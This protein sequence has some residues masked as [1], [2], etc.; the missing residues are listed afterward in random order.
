MYLVRKD[1]RM[2][3]RVKEVVQETKKLIYVRV[4]GIKGIFFVKR[5]GKGNN[6]IYNRRP[7]TW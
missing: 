2:L 1:Q 4:E 7:S 3:C 5:N 6:K